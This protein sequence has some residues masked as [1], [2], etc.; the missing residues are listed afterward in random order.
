MHSGWFKINGFQIQL[1][2][3]SH[4]WLNRAANWY[5]WCCCC[6]RRTAQM[7]LIGLI[8]VKNPV[9]HGIFLFYSSWMNTNYYLYL[10]ASCVQ[11]C[12]IGHS[13]ECIIYVEIA[14]SSSR[15]S[16]HSTL[17]LYICI[18]L[19]ISNVVIDH[20]A[21]AMQTLILH[22]RI[23]LGAHQFQRNV[24]HGGTSKVS[25]QCQQT[26]EHEQQQQQ[27]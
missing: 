12:T 6:C 20:N 13:E 11:C 3:N 15:A 22:R 18:F 14:K 10:C 27:K 19:E 2:F 25:G 7:W 21:D 26:R 5:S 8:N 9:L 23:P 16:L 1:R 17:N 4:I 24:K